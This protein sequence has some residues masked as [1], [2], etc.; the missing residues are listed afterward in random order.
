MPEIYRE[1]LASLSQRANGGGVREF[2]Q[3]MALGRTY[4]K[5]N[6]EQAMKQALSENL[7]EAERIRQLINRESY[8][9]C[10]SAKPDSYPYQVKV[11]LPDLSRFDEL[12]LVN[13]SGGR[14]PN[15]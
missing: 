15:E 2:L 12:R 9:G 5:E 8:T 11:I 10:I 14:L 1:F 13:V 6:L 3:V 7:A 4:G